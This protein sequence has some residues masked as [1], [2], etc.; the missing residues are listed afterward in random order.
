[1]YK[2]FLQ[3][4][5]ERYLYK[6]DKLSQERVRE[7]FDNLMANPELG[8]PLTG[9][10]AGLWSLRIGKYRALYKVIHNELVI[11]IIDLDKRDRIYE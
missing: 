2:L 8:K 11:I 1:M 9:K 4:K 6:L 7:K 3:K 10:L 5:V